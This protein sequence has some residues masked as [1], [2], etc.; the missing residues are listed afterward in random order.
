MIR[1]ATIAILATAVVSS[2]GC[3]GEDEAAS[4]DQEAPLSAT[5]TT[6]T[7]SPGDGTFTVRTEEFVDG[8]RQTSA[9]IPQRRLVTDIYVPGG[10]GP[11]P[12]VVHAHGM[13][14]TS[15]KFSELLGAWAEAG[16]LVVAPNFPRTNGD[17]GAELRDLGD[18]VN[19]PADMTFVLDSVLD[20]AGQGGELEGL[21]AEDHIGVSGLSLGGATTYP[22]LFNDCCRDDRYR[23]G[24]LMSA[25]EL[26]YDDSAYDYTRRIPVLAFSGTD[27]ASIPYE[28][29]QDT[30]AKVAG[31][32][33]N[34]TLPGGQ[35]S[36]P[37]ENR[38]SPQ[39]ELVVAT[40]IA[41]WD[42]TLRGD[43][44][45]ADRLVR[46]ATVEGLSFV[47]VTE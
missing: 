41:F 11:F 15:A 32:K 16:Y 47:D 44:G 7:L 4:P 40:T 25:L 5:E 12:M 45:A 23:S 3:S 42:M 31:P 30:I 33:W 21:V 1:A 14:G 36:Q 39:D 6:T 8:S 34:V 20:M 24:L 13:D 18:Y 26:P 9:E 43:A 29:Q 38:P 22:L 19:Q 27:D 17:A 46:S 2:T 37:F 35:H 28:V 10:E